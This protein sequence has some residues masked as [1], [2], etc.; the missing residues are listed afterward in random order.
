M[1]PKKKSATAQPKPDGEPKAPKK[2]DYSQRAHDTVREVEKRHA[3]RHPEE[4]AD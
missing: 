2:R 1:M 4:N 3:E